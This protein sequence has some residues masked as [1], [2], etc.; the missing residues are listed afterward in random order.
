MQK[1]GG[2]S[3]NFGKRYNARTGDSVQ[4]INQ[5]S[6]FE[7]KVLKVIKK[8]IEGKYVDNFGNYSNIG[9]TTTP[10]G[11]SLSGQGSAVGTHTGDSIHLQ[12]L[13]LRVAAYQ[14]NT[15]A[16]Q[17]QNIVRVIVFRW[18]QNSNVTTPSATSVLTVASLAS[19]GAS[20]CSDYNV[21]ELQNGNLQILYDQY[22]FTSLNGSSAA[23]KIEME[24]D[25]DVAFSPGSSAGTGHLY[26]LVISDDA[27]VVSPCPSY[28]FYSRVTFMD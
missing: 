27:G 12:H 6:K 2:V 14:N 25:S 20:I 11:L 24:L 17:P 1:A 3:H 8:E 26:L 5:S 13:V 18:N 4:G 10:V 15:T 7:K 28:A 21:L 16:V 19:A 22:L 9:A 23:V